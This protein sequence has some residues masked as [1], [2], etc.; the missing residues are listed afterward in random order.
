MSLSSRQKSNREYLGKVIAHEIKE[1]IL[2]K[3]ENAE[4]EVTVK[5]GLTQCAVTAFTSVHLT[6]IEVSRIVSRIISPF[7]LTYVEKPYSMYKKEN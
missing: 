1:L 2:S 4:S 6:L 7:D 5:I 3:D